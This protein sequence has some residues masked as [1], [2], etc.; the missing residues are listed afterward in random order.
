M[1]EATSTPVD[2][3]HANP[4]APTPTPESAPAPDNA[5]AHETA[6]TGA[7]GTPAADAASPEATAERNNAGT[8][9]GKAELPPLTGAEATQYAILKTC[10]QLGRPLP[11]GFTPKKSVQERFDRERAAGNA[12]NLP[13]TPKDSGGQKP[14]NTAKA[15]VP[16]ADD[17]LVKLRAGYATADPAKVDALISADYYLQANAKF[18]PAA[19]VDMKPELRVQ[20]A[21]TLKKRDGDVARMAGRASPSD[22]GKPKATPPDGKPLPGKTAEPP[23]QPKTSDVF[24]DAPA[25]VREALS[26]LDEEEAKALSEFIAAKA[27]PPPKPDAEDDPAPEDEP[28]FDARE[29]RLGQAHARDVEREAEKEFPWLKQ[30]GGRQMVAAKVQAVAEQLGMWPR[31]LLD[32]DLLSRMYTDAASAVFGK[33]LRA[34]KMAAVKAAVITEAP[35]RPPSRAARNGPPR[36]LSQTERV[37]IAARAAKDAKGDP[38]RNAE[39]FKQYLEE[40]RYTG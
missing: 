1:P 12:A 32:Y 40:A 22:K 2:A 7:G 9:S 33:E 36:D 24:S 4:S 21:A 38:K 8:E 29:V 25:K 11:P 28:V 16:G 14:S 5:G 10:H 23:Q 13:D 27:T 39:L 6:P 35:V 31:V 15:P 37:Q 20:L 17:P 30:P 19:L 3:S 34:S 26:L 18:D